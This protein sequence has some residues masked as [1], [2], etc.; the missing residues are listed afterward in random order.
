M[1]GNTRGQKP[2]LKSG[3]RAVRIVFFVLLLISTQ[4]KASTVTAINYPEFKSSIVKENPYFNYP[5]LLI[6]DKGGTFSK[7]LFGKDIISLK[8][9]AELSTKI[10]ID[11]LKALQLSIPQLMRLNSDQKSYIIITAS[12]CTPCESII[13]EF[14]EKTLPNLP[15]NDNI[16][17][18]NLEDF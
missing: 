15:S 16:I 3:K 17:T 7:G 2:S 9:K 12:F 6:F 14:R 1:K 11:N 4:L 13:S 8:A 18:L 10:K 5:A